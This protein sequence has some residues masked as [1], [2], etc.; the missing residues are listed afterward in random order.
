MPYYTSIAYR[1]ALALYDGFV[2][3]QGKNN[4]GYFNKD[5]EKKFCQKMIKEQIKDKKYIIKSYFNPWLKIKNEQDVFCRKINR[6]FLAGLP[7]KEFII[8]HGQFNDLRTKMW[9][10]GILIEAFDP[11]GKT[12][13]DKYLVKNNL[14]ISPGDLDVLVKPNG[15]NFIQKE[16]LD[17]LLI[18]K[19]FKKGGKI[20]FDVIKHAQEYHWLNNTWADIFCLDKDYFSKL[21]KKDFKK[22]IKVIDRQIRDLREYGS[23]TKN[24]MKKLID[25]YEIPS[26]MINILELFSVMS[27]WRDIRKGQMMK[28][29]SFAEDF[30]QELKERSKIE[31]RYLLYLDPYEVSSIR[32]LKGLEDGLKKRGKCCLHYLERI[33]TKWF[34]E[35]QALKFYNLLQNKII[36][37]EEVKGVTACRGKASGRIKIIISLD[38]FFKMKT[39]DILVTQMTRPEYLPVIKKAGAII[40]DEGGITCHAAI[41]SRELGIPCVIGTQIATSVLKDG[42]LVEVDADKGVVK[43]IKNFTRSL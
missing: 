26:E 22:D 35:K 21:I 4:Y 1:A 16:L 10:K 36:Q 41:I 42:Q 32:H 30:L 2:F 3:Y 43:V 12:L 38:D 37:S 17:R 18:V 19:K 6:E 9:S 14:N 23:R 8:I 34:T 15:L 5:I 20:D 27:D 40:T 39:G 25:K 7:E 33:K 28:I 29:N 24:K 11:W 31:K 13:I